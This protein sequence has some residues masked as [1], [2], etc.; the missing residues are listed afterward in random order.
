MPMKIVT[1][2]QWCH[3]RPL[4]FVNERIAADDLSLRKY[5][6]RSGERGW[7]DPVADTYN[8]IRELAISIIMCIFADKQY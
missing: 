6:G 1:P 8:N 7:K 4:S 3:T 5:P 2:A